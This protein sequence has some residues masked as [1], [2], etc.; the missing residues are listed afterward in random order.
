MPIIFYVIKEIFHKEFVVIGQ[1]VNSA[2][3]CDILWQL[4]EN[5]RR[6]RPDL[7][8]Q[9]NWLLHHDNALA[10]PFQPGTFF[11]KSNMTV[12]PTHPTSLIW[13]PAPFLS[14]LD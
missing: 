6:L 2:Y 7:W 9:K 8:R 14:F 5:V 3:Y 11:T 10:L 1:T 4:R 13:P 12:I